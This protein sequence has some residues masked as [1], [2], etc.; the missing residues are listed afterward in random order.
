MLSKRTQNRRN[1]HTIAI[2]TEDT[3]ES[4]L[5]MGRHERQPGPS[6]LILAPVAVLWTPENPLPLSPAELRAADSTG[7]DRG[8]DG[9]GRARLLSR[10]A[11]Q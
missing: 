8:P 7:L 10:V 11:L 4:S 9:T 6:R 3:G 5:G 2:A 1:K